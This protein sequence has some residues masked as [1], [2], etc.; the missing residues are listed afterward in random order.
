[1]EESKD[2]LYFRLFILFP[3]LLYNFKLS[4]YIIIFAFV[5]RFLWI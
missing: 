3:F 4:K 2:P 1:M 5:F